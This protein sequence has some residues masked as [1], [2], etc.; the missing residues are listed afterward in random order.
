MG[1][2]F[3]WE[4]CAARDELI[5][6]IWKPVESTDWWKRE[7]HRV[8]LI[9]SKTAWTVHVIDNEI[10][11]DKNLSHSFPMAWQYRFSDKGFAGEMKCGVELR[12][13]PDLS[14]ALGDKPFF[15]LQKMGLSEDKVVCFGTSDTYNNWDCVVFSPTDDRFRLWYQQAHAD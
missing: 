14:G 8:A 11:K 9:W 5:L 10:E 13:D 4:Q 2:K 7:V 12:K 3:K 15:D 1:G 6:G